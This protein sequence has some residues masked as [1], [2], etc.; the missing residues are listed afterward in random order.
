MV[1]GCAA[2]TAEFYTLYN[3]TLAMY[4]AG[5]DNWSR[6][7]DAVRDAVVAN[8]TKGTGCER[9]SWDPKGTFAGDP[10]GRIYSTALATLMLEVYYRFSREG[11]ATVLDAPHDARKRDSR[12]RPSGDRAGTRI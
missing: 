5:G 6:W 12:S 2:G 8:Q 10:G 11:Q 4:Q 7:N 1:T 3:A 9:G